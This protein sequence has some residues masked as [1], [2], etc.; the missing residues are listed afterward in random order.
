MCDQGESSSR[1]FHRDVSP[2]MER[3]PGE[4]RVQ[5]TAEAAELHVSLA[6]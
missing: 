1:R 2:S 5:L 3:V 6:H 4:R